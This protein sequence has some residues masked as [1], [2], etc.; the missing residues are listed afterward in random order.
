MAELLFI[1]LQWATF[2]HSRASNHLV[3]SLFTLWSSMLLPIRLSLLWI[4]VLYKIFVALFSLVIGAM[5]HGQTLF[6]GHYVFCKFAQLSYTGTCLSLIWIYILHCLSFFPFTLDFF[7]ETSGFST[8][9]KKSASP[10]T[11]GAPPP[12]ML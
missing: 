10:A 5:G 12:P 11:K 9:V 2:S 3:A 8:F 6:I 7:Q 1:K 4:C